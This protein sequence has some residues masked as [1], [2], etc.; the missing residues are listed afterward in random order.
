M[1]TIEFQGISPWYADDDDRNAINGQLSDSKT[2]P[3]ALQVA[4]DYFENTDRQIIIEAGK[5]RNRKYECMAFRWDASRGF[6]AIIGCVTFRRRP[7][8]KVA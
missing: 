2:F 4:N 7:R 5:R 1:T 8:V 3:D 6:W